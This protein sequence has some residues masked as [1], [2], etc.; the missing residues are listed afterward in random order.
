[1]RYF[2]IIGHRA[3]TTPQLSLND[4]A[5]TG[6]RMDLIARSV[7]ASFCISHD[8]RRDVE[9]ALILLGPE[10]PPKT[11]RIFGSELKYLNPDERSTGAL[12]RNALIKSVSKQSMEH[13]RF[14]NNGIKKQPSMETQSLMGELNSSPG[15][16]ISRNGLEEVLEHYSKKSTLIHLHENGQDITKIKIPI[17]CT[18]VLSDDKDFTPDEEKLISNYT[19]H[20]IS[21]GPKI[22]HTDHCIS[23]IHNYLD[24]A[25]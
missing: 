12:I 13:D 21:L 16:F 22:I 10:D 14:M 3:V 7:N 4:L 23:I 6:G 15:I 1:M 17:D 5:G 24:R 19:T 2:I 18:T 25:K 8:I 20:K 9:V 11:I